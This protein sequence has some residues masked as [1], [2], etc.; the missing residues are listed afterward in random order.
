MI[1]FTEKHHAEAAIDYFN[2]E[3]RYSLVFTACPF[4]PLL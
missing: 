4:L 2:G 3:T 1:T